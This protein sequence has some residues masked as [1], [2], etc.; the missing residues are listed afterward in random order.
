M[1]PRVPVQKVPDEDDDGGAYPAQPTYPGPPAPRRYNWIWMV[2]AALAIAFIAAATTAVFMTGSRAEKSTTSSPPPGISASSPSGSGSSPTSGA[3]S[4]DGA[5][6]T[7]AP[8]ADAHSNPVGYLEGMRAQID[9][10]IAQ[11]DGVMDA[12]AGRDLQNA[13]SDME[14]ATRAAQQ[15]GMKGKSLKN[16]TTKTDRLGSKINDY[17]SG[18][19]ISDPTASALSGELQTFSD[20]LGSG[21]GGDNGNN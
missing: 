9:G 14:N 5:V 6:S 16:L 21:G 1:G 8:T 3:S 7:G 15:N 20:A 12:N 18:G 4:T 19:L 2:L 10:F 13:L 11:G 17:H